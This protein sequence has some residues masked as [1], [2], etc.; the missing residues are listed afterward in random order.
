MIGD[1]W[2]KLFKRSTQKTVEQ[3]EDTEPVF[4][5]QYTL[6]IP[7][8]MMLDYNCFFDCNNIPVSY[9]TEISSGGF[10][11]CLKLPNTAAV[12][13]YLT[14]LAKSNTKKLLNSKTRTISIV[15]MRHDKQVLILPD[16]KQAKPA[17]IIAPFYGKTS[18]K[19]EKDCWVLYVTPEINRTIVN[20]IKTITR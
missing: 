18:T 13:E 20:Q 2:K 11:D 1:F 19:H 15:K 16:L 4:V 3:P 7:D 17:V 6:V 9:E 14:Q 12:R 10:H 5:K 8:N